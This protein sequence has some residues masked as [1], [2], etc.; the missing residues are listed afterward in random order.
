MQ[1]KFIIDKLN[2]FYYNFI[3]RYLNV[4]NLMFKYIINIIKCNLRF[5]KKKLYRLFKLDL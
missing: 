2:Q 5:Y 3:I 1:L 4:V